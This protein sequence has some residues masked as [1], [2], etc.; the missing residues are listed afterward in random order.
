MNKHEKQQKEA[1]VFN[2]IIRELSRA[3][4][5]YQGV[6]LDAVYIKGI[7]CYKVLQ[8]GVGTHWSKTKVRFV[9]KSGILGFAWLYQLL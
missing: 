5:L 3:P 7:N 8:S 9:T 1:I 6:L 2:S 4:G